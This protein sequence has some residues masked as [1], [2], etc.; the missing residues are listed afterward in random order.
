MPDLEYLQGQYFEA[1]EA[2]RDALTQPLIDGTGMIGEAREKFAK[3]HQAAQDIHAEIKHWQTEAE[4]RKH[5]PRDLGMGQKQLAPEFAEFMR[6]GSLQKEY[7]LKPGADQVL[8]KGADLRKFYGTGDTGGGTSGAGYWYTTE[9]WP[10]VIMGL[11]AASGVLEA[12]PTLV[13]T[14]HL[15]PIQ[16]PV[17]TADAT[18]VAGAEGSDATA[19]ETVATGAMLSAY[20]YDGALSVSAETIMSADLSPGVDELMSTF[21]VRALA[22][23]T[24]AQLALGDGTTEPV[25]VFTASI[26][27]AGVTAASATAVL[28]DEMIGLV[29]SVGKGYRKRSQLVV[30]DVL[31]THMLKWKDDTDAYV[32]RSTDGGGY[33]F[34]GYPV[35]TEPQADQTSMSASEVH[36]V[37]GSFADG[38][39]VRFS[40]FLFA[41]DDSNPLL[42]LFRFAQW[43]DAAVTDTA[44]LRSLK[45][46]T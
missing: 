8:V 7:W 18:A 42:V 11:Q 13:I 28:P 35:F 5:G 34:A 24:A 25:G 44:A 19:A 1:I 15:R 27:T 22:D 2:Q 6:P 26:V 37:F 29:K 16:I 20:R 14:N 4:L 32:L 21:A 31:H 39:V 45:M 40:P 30:S 33:Q 43:I 36:A 9:Q 12:G 38:L 17:L 46:G 23:Q 3:A 10:E 41:K